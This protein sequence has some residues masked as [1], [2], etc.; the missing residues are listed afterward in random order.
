MTLVSNATYL[1][2]KFPRPGP[3]S[4]NQPCGLPRQAC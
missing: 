1:F 4:V 3:G 2:A